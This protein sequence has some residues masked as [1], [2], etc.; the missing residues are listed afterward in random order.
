M[1]FS[2][3]VVLD[4]SLGYSK[5]RWICGGKVVD[6]SSLFDGNLTMK[7]LK[8]NIFPIDHYCEFGCWVLDACD[9]GRY[10]K[11]VSR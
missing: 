8:S 2:G 11:L 10:V 5:L 6:D 1:T 4:L 3:D 9:A 7:P